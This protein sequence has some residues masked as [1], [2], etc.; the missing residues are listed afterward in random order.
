MLSGSDFTVEQGP[1][2]YGHSAVWYSQV[3]EARNVPCA[4]LCILDQL[5]LSVG[6]SAITCEFNVN[7]PFK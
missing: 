7:K 1:P 2:V 4:K 6:Y 3:Q 5:C